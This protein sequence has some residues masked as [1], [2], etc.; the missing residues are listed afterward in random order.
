MKSLSNEELISKIQHTVML[1]GDLDPDYPIE[2]H[3]EDMD[4][5]AELSEVKRKLRRKDAN[6]VE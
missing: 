3:L 1:R 6:E 2:R 4:F 5:I